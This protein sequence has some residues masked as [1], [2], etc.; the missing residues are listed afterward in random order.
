MR[1]LIYVESCH[2]VDIREIEA[3]N[4]YLFHPYEYSTENTKAVFFYGQN[5]IGQVKIQDSAFSDFLGFNN[6][7]TQALLDGRT[8]E[9]DYLNE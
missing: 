3:T 4:N 2:L 1:A 6:L 5:I 9:L 7:K 8:D